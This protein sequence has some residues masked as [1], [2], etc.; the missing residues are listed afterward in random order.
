[1]SHAT[2]VG[3]FLVGGI[4]LF[5]VG[6]FLIGSSSQLFGHHFTIYTNFNDVDTLQSGAKVR[7]S[8][9]D[10]G[11]VTNVQVPSGPSSQFRLQ[12][13]VEKKFQPVIRQ[14]SVASIETEGMVG[15]KYVNIQK[16]TSNSPVCEGCTLRSQEPVSMGALMREGS[17]L[18]G[19]MK[20]TIQ[21]VQRRAD[22]AIQN[23]TS[24]AGHADKLIVAVGPKA[25][26]I[27]AN[28]VR[29]SRNVGAIT[30][31]I[32][33]GKGAAGK[34]LTDKTVA[35][36][37]ETTIANAKQTTANIK[38]ASRKVNVVAANAQNMSQQLNQA[39]GTFLAPG[40][41]NENTAE[42]LRDA[43]QGA[44]Q[45]TTNLADDTEAIKTNFFL[46]GFFNRRGFY[47]LSTLT[48]SKYADTKFVK[49]PRARV[50]V[51][52]AGLFR[53]GKDGLPELTDVGKAILD[54][55]MSD[56][57]PYLPNN[58][59]MVEGYADKGMEDQQYLA[60]RQRAIEVR[61]YLE[62]RFHLNSK[63]IGMM[64]LGSH[65]PRGA[66][67]QSW[68]GVCLVLVVSKK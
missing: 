58:P 31:D 41:N 33:Q 64:P 63:R 23:I 20:S 6:L 55:S 40:N 27:A 61:N 29:I 9:M 59:I 22:S 21:D 18:A 26:Q 16:G 50:W 65:P 62:S 54:Q 53:A 13:K 34:L 67:K 30:T 49:R 24:A 8:G 2:K 44:K 52:A 11:E 57:V 14:D 1:M 38:Q 15:N 66:G 28:S 39:V 37:V 3:I 46:R 32:R 35:A 17:E 25:N 43:A 47:N 68:D 45:A 48:P 12:L 36:N 42:A 4:V 5:C 10:A 19:T 56:L 7:V 51:P 60:S